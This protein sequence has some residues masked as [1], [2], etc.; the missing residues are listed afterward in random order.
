MISSGATKHHP[1]KEPGEPVP[2]KGLS[3]YSILEQKSFCNCPLFA[4]RFNGQTMKVPNYRE[5]IEP[6]LRLLVESREGQEPQAVHDLAADALALTQ[7]QRAVE[8]ASGGAT[9]RN[10]VGWAFNTLKHSQLV[11]TDGRGRWHATQKGKEYAAEHAQLGQR[12]LAELVRTAKNSGISDRASKLTTKPLGDPKAVG[13][14][15]AYRLPPTPLARGGQAEVFTA[16]RKSDGSK[17]AFKRVRGISHIERMR[18]EIT[19]QTALS[20]P[21]IMPIVDWDNHKHSW[22]V[23]PL[24]Q[25]SLNERAIPLPED[26]IISVLEAIIPALALAHGKDIPHRDLKPSNI[27]RLAD[28]SGQ[29]RWVLADWGLAR[30]AVGDTTTGLT[31]TGQMLGSEGFASPEAYKDPHRVGP[32]GDIYALGQIIHWALGGIPLP[33]STSSAPEPWKGIVAQATQLDPA[34]RQ[35]SALEVLEQ[36]RK[37]RPR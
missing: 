36:A 2:A 30:W 8:V 29:S 14:R 19:I 37:L 26:E 11:S 35:G 1:L 20:H 23:M 9:Y 10:R 28:A 16:V 13:D 7:E 5:F 22:Y 17:F 32:S 15:R 27:I 25:G 33:N 3:N 31:Q 24:G 12:Q 6:V 34:Q 21:N 18:R 4:D